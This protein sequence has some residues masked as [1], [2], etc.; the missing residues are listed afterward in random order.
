MRAKCNAAQTNFIKEDFV[1]SQPNWKIIILNLNN[2][3]KWGVPL[4]PAF[5]FMSYFFQFEKANWFY[6]MQN[7]KRH[8]KRTETDNGWV[9]LC[10]QTLTVR[11]GPQFC[12]ITALHLKRETTAVRFIAWCY[13]FTHSALLLSES[14]MKIK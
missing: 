3:L 10:N 12:D 1:K 6:P 5:T 4:S 2:T 13:R 9:S 7:Q 8:I 14:S 11:D